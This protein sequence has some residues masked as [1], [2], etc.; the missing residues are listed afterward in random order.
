MKLLFLVVVTLIGCSPQGRFQNASFH[1]SS[2][3]GGLEVSALD[4]IAGSTV[5]VYKITPANKSITTCT[6]NVIA[7][8]V[9][10]TAAHCVASADERNYIYF[11]ATIPQDIF[12]FF[13][14]QADI[15]VL[16]VVVS[17]AIPEGWKTDGV[18]PEKDWSDLALLKIS[19]DLPA[20]FHPIAI[21]DNIPVN[22]SA[23]SIAGFGFTDGVQHVRS[24]DL[25]EADVSVLDGQWSSSEI[26]LDTS[27]GKASC[28]GDSGGPAYVA[29]SQGLQLLAIDSR[30]ELKSD[31]N[32]ECV[33]DTIY[34]RLG[35][36]KSWIE[37]EI[38]ILNGQP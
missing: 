29:S 11:S 13:A 37:S 1:T 36:Y 15:N 26:L 33:G 4:P 22:N 7:N 18:K 28:H 27:K 35:F 25:R 20:G 21:S 32:F 17:S 30:S 9:I 6:G 10:L 24:Q 38:R 8:Q 12:Q 16:R 14:A 3:V 2:I 23:I 34:T 5:Q 31:P 19:G